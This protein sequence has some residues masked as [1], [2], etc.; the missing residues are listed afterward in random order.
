MK[1]FKYKIFGADTLEGVYGCLRS[2]LKEWL[3]AAKAKDL[4]AKSIGKVEESLQVN[5]VKALVPMSM[6]LDQLF[7]VHLASG[8]DKII[9]DEGV[10]D[11]GWRELDASLQYLCLSMRCSLKFDESRGKN[12]QSTLNS[13]LLWSYGFFLSA[14]LGRGSL[15]K[16]FAEALKGYFDTE[17]MPE[18]I[19]DEAYR[20]YLAA[21]VFTSLGAPFEVSRL[22]V[23]RSIFLNDVMSLDDLDAMVEHHVIRTDY[24]SKYVRSEGVDPVFGAAGIDLMPVEILY[25][26]MGGR[27]I[28]APNNIFLNRWLAFSYPVSLKDS[29]TKV[30]LYGEVVNKV[31]SC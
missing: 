13:V 16:E 2:E 20:N 5:G 6:A 17:V 30:E 23:Y 15:E 14:I 25:G 4:L 12:Y 18:V 3:E 21:T 31:S 24:E 1:S 9:S 19:R 7:L 10:S 27:S 29:I 11:E 28:D 8:V 22:G 26:I